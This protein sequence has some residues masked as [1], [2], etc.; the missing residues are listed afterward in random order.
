MNRNKR[1]R[2]KITPRIKQEKNL[3]EEDACMCQITKDKTHFLFYNN[4]K[5]IIRNRMFIWQNENNE[6][7]KRKIEL[8]NKM[9]YFF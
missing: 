7:K 5:I 8:K 3:I 4:E 2:Y 9:E 6:K 1:V